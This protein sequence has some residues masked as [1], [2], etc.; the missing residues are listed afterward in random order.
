M[1]T[2]IYCNHEWTLM[3]SNKQSHH[4]KWVECS[5][6]AGAFVS[7]KKVQRWQQAPC[8][9]YASRGLRFMERLTFSVVATVLLVAI[10]PGFTLAAE[11]PTEQQL[12]Q[13]LQSDRSLG[14]KD[15]ACAQLKRIGTESSIRALAA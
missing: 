8:T 14:E 2:L 11:S 3:N 13:I 7:G 4:T 1:N 15:A 12:I 5:Q 6:L 10:L 9:P